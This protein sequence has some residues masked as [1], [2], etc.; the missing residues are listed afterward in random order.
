MRIT[1]QY[2]AQLRELRGLEE[3]TLETDAPTAEVLYHELQARYCFP[4][5][6]QQIGIAINDVYAKA[7]TA[8]HPGD[9]VVFISHISGG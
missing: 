4:D 5:P 7:H 6:V 3:E 1:I 8:L 2:F 9:L